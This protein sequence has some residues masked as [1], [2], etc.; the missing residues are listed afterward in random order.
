MWREYAGGYQDW[1]NYQATRRADET[2]ATNAAKRGGDLPPGEATKPTRQKAAAAGKLSWKES[3]EL[4]ELPQR[5]AALEAE[6]ASIGERLADPAL[7]QSQ[8]QEAQRLSTRSSEIDEQLLL[9]L[10]RWEAL[11]G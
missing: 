6:Q 2:P 1:A 10:E 4:A 7:Y 5:I 3:R 9:L 11:E 8:P